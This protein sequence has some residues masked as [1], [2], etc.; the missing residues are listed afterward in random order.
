MGGTGEHPLAEDEVDIEQ[1]KNT[2][3]K[4]LIGILIFV[5]VGLPLL[6]ILV[7]TVLVMIG[8]SFSST[9]EDEQLQQGNKPP[10]VAPS[11]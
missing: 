11:E 9:F 4:I 5:F 3:M 2:V 6:A 7:I 10:I 1:P 8:S